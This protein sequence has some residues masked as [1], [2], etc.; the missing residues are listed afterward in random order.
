MVEANHPRFEFVIQE[1]N[2]KL[3]R[4]NH[5]KIR[6]HATKAVVAA[7]RKR[8]PLYP[9]LQPLP[10]SDLEVLLS[11]CG[12]THIDCSA[13]ASI[14]LGDTAA[15]LLRKDPTQLKSVL[16]CRQQSYFSFIPARFGKVAVLD[17]AFRALITLAHSLVAPTKSA[18]PLVAF[19]HYGKALRSL[20]SAVDDP[21]SRYAPETL[22]AVG[23]LALFEVLNPS[24]IKLWNRH[25]DGASRLIQAR[26][27]GRF[28]SDFDGSLLTTLG[29][30]ICANALLTGQECFLATPPWQE[31]LSGLI[32]TDEMF[33]ERS[34]LTVTNLMLMS[35]L[36]GLKKET[37]EVIYAHGRGELVNTDDLV[38]RLREHRARE[39]AWRRDYNM[40]LLL[41]AES[42][43]SQGEKEFDKRYELLGM[44]FIMRIFIN[45]F[46][47]SLVSKDCSFLEEE[48]LS[49]A[50]EL[51]QLHDTLM[52]HNS[53]HYRAGWF[54]TQKVIIATL[55]FAT[56]D[57]YIKADKDE[58]IANV[59][60]WQRFTKWCDMRRLANPSWN[61]RL[62]P[63]A[64]NHSRPASPEV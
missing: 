32:N 30:P 50:A 1:P 11:D 5:S 52:Q 42:Y 45:R 19:G 24:S 58:P 16:S 23:I 51:K 40:A 21:N 39:T 54:L 33:T 36:G 38:R 49:A 27:P 20:Q 18:R 43:N 44:H 17:D 56:H 35:Q 12:L 63:E 53:A 61:A 6:R 10:L 4:E 2:A 26:G 7:R 55:V 14:H 9:L 13:L 48:V 34:P 15:V 31:T 60:T 28:W 46:L 59:A 62:Q 41:A 25:I 64:T 22:C 47:C 57:D 37:A 29:S 8:D 3:S